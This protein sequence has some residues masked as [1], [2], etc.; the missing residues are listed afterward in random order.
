MIKKTLSFFGVFLFL[1]A[2]M[3]AQVSSQETGSIRG[4]ITDE[5][6]N[7]LPGV[8]IVVTGPSLMGKATD[9][10]R[11]DGSFRILLLPPGIYTLVAE[12]QGFKTYR[13][14]GIEVRVGLTIT[15]N[16][17]MSI[18]TVKEEVTVVGAAPVVDVKSSKT[19]QVYKSDLI[20][21]L[22]IARNLSSIISLTPGTVDPTNIKG[23]TAAGNTYQ[24]DGLNANDPTQQQLMI[25]V[26]FNLIEEVEILT[27]GAPAEVGWTLGGFVNAVTKSGGNKFSGI[28]QTYYTDDSLTKLVLPY[29]EIRTLG[30]SK[31]SAPLYDYEISG[32][33]GGPI[34][35][36]RIWFYVDGRYARNSYHSGFIPFTSPYDGTYY[37][38]YDRKSYLWAGMMKLTFQLSN[39][40]R[41][42]VMGNVQPS[43]T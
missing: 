33:V 10:T 8:N 20:Q 39:N 26:D 24:I 32:G 34:I 23:S 28:F 17:K 30:L 38:N 1:S 22:P 16:I 4:V 19:E 42:A 36:D 21:N 37:D 7:P 18:A 40:L 3:F 43:Y 41:L 27:G 13:E 29:D 9:V 12:I 14:E 35:K 5:E 2:F 11:S 15:R 31:P 25:P 6:G